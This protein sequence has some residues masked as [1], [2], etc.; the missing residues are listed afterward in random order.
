MKFP[1]LGNVLLISAFVITIAIA[2]WFMLGDP[3]LMAIAGLI[4]VNAA[5]TIIS[6]I[7]KT[8]D[9]HL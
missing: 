8:L 3:V 5:D 4:S 9:E 2:W 1:L 7:K 6:M